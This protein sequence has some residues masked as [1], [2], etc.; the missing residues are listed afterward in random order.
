MHYFLVA[1][2]EHAI[3]GPFIFEF[4][5]NVIYGKTENENCKAIEDLRKELCKSEKTIQITDFGAGSNINNST[6]RKVKDLAKNSAKNEKFGKLLYRIIQF[7]KPKNIIEL[8]TSLGISA[9]YLAKA[10][11]CRKG[12]YF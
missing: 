5:T 12:I 3:Q 8:G 11:P 4:V 6:K 2:N 10:K 1:K 7:Y 9:C